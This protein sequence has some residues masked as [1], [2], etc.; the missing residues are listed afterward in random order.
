MIKLPIA[1]DDSAKTSEYNLHQKLKELGLMDEK[2]RYVVPPSVY[3]KEERGK[4]RIK[5]TAS[6]SDDYKALNLSEYDWAILFQ[7]WFLEGTLTVD[8]DHIIMEYYI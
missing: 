5:E 6:I 1:C 3:E 4:Y 8:D 7:L 2:G